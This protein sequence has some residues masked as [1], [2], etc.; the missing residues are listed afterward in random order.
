MSA[1][2]H[3][4]FQ[5]YE[6]LKTEYSALAEYFGKVITFRFTTAAFFI[7]A[8]AFVVG[9]A[10]PGP[11]EHALLFAMS[12]GIW[13]VEL[14]N[15]GI[16]ETLLH[17]G[18]QIE[19]LWAN[20]WGGQLPLF[21]HLTPKSAHD[22]GVVF[23]P[24]QYRTF[25]RTRILV[26]GRFHFHPISHT[27]GL[28]ILY[29]SVMVYALWSLRGKIQSFFVQG[30]TMDPVSALL[31]F[32]I[33]LVGYKLFRNAPDVKDEKLRKFL[34]IIGCLMIVGAIIIIVFAVRLLGSG[35]ASAS[36][37]IIN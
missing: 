14:R 13:I 3:P 4:S 18:W 10:T 20:S 5:P 2:P 8:V 23:I 22:S 34:L 33:I 15:R 37:P 12:L 30:A 31:A 28:D 17:R 36:S 25:D 29:L 7:V 16:F 26:F 24:E 32:A 11:S 1:K 21:M 19:R 9:R 6:F 35:S 27:L